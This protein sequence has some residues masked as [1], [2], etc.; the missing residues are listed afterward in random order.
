MINDIE[1]CQP[2]NN[3]VIVN[4]PRRPHPWTSET[5]E[6]FCS[7]YAASK[8]SSDHLVRAYHETYGLQTSICNCSNND[9]PYQFPEKLIP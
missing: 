5:F 2:F 4:L 9:G 3:D 7:P 6:Q 1:L 8:A